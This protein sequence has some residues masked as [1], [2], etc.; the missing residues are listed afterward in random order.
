MSFL[1]SLFARF[2][3]RQQ[4]KVIDYL[5]EENRVLREQLGKRRLRLTDEQRARLAVKAKA[6]GRSVLEAV[7]SIVTPD[8]L[9]RW[10]HTLVAAKWTFASKTPRQPGRPPVMAW[11]RELTIRMARDNKWGYTRIVGALRNLGH[12]VART[13]VAKILKRDSSP[14]R[15][16]EGAHPLLELPAHRKRNLSHRVIRRWPNRAS[17]LRWLSRMAPFASRAATVWSSKSRTRPIRLTDSL[18]RA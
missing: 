3:N 7:A 16:A 18:D 12:D 8:T 1:L 5:R 17:I 10:H 6:L 9:L 14:G 11:I 15:S 4:A 13:T 2:V